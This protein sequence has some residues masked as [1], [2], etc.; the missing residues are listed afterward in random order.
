MTVLKPT[1]NSI[2][3]IK[4]RV[5]AGIASVEEQRDFEKIEQMSKK[6]SDLSLSGLKKMLRALDDHTTTQILY[7]IQGKV[8][9]KDSPLKRKWSG[10]IRILINYE[11]IS[12]G[13]SGK[14]L[15]QDI[16]GDFYRAVRELYTEELAKVPMNEIPGMFYKKLRLKWIKQYKE[17]IERRKN[18]IPATNKDLELLSHFQKDGH[19][20]PENRQRLF[21]YFQPMEYIRLGDEEYGLLKDIADRLG[22]SEQTIRNYEKRG[23]IKQ[24]QRKPHSGEFGITELRVIPPKDIDRVV[25]EIRPFV[26]LAELPPEGYMTTEEFCRVYNIHRSAISR[27]RKKGKATFVKRGR[28]HFYKKL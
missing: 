23:L 14:N 12:S 2:S 21:G 25:E 16:Y 19:L 9:L 10:I 17:E 22:V 8:Q 1:K 26:E 24:F 27:W 6:L 7:I 20:S 4:K 18:V 15:E 5:E 28:R 3:E 11:K 13:F